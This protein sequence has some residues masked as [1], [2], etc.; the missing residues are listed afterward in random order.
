MGIPTK[1]N[2]TV[3]RKEQIRELRQKHEKLF[4]L[5]GLG[6]KAK[7]V[8]KMAYIPRA[9]AETV[10]A[11]FPSEIESGE[12]LYT[13][14]VSKQNI[15]EDPERRLWKWPFNPEYDIEYEKTAPHPGTGHIRYLVPVAELIDVASVHQNTLIK[16]AEELNDQED[17]F[18]FDLPDANTDAPINQMTIRDKAAIDWKLPVSAK[19]WLNDLIRQTF[20]N[21]NSNE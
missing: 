19:P 5:E 9:G 12:D 17:E 7:F 15:P 20:K 18:T 13:E 3:S 14:F 4:E 21:V 11:F 16:P 1:S 8:P 10:I 6:D 2:K